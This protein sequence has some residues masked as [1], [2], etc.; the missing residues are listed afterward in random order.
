MKPSTTMPSI[1]ETRSS[2]KH[3]GSINIILDRYDRDGDGNIDQDEAEEMAKDLKEAEKKLEPF[4]SRA[5]RMLDR[6]C[7]TKRTLTRYDLDGNG[8]MG[9]DEVTLMAKDLNA[10]EKKVVK[11]DKAKKKYQKWTGM[12]AFVL[13]L[14]LVAN[15]GLAIA[16][17]YLTRQFDVD[18]GNLV[19]KST[20]EQVNTKARGNLIEVAFETEEEK[21]WN[22][23]PYLT[24]DACLTTITFQHAKYLEYLAGTALHFSVEIEG[25][26]NGGFVIDGTVTHETYK[27][28]EG[29]ICNFYK[30]IR[31]KSCSIEPDDVHQMACC[32]TDSGNCCINLDGQQQEQ[33]LLSGKCL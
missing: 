4:H 6:G 9:K 31:C 21:H 1:D 3:R 23:G 25:T 12:T 28:D 19:D 27:N 13:F 24:D 30:N 33:R 20:G 10:A 8:T 5:R 26:T 18:D 14:T 16:T 11:V 15:F 22:T 32:G 2:L 29:L 17:I 7:S